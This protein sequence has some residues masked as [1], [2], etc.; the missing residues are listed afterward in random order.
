M[1]R[2]RSWHRARCFTWGWAGWRIE[3]LV[4][5]DGTP[6]STTLTFGVDPTGRSWEKSSSR[7]CRQPGTGMPASVITADCSSTYGQMWRAWRTRCRSPTSGRPV[8]TAGTGGVPAKL[9]D[10]FGGILGI[11]VDMTT[12]NTLTVTNAAIGALNLTFTSTDAFFFSLPL[13]PEVLTFT[14]VPTNVFSTVP[15][16]VV[17]NATD[18]SGVAQAGVSVTISQATGAGSI[19]TSGLTQTTNTSG[20]ATFT[21][22]YTAVAD[23]EAFSLTA[24]TTDCS[25]DPVTVDWSFSAPLFGPPPLN[26][27]PAARA[28]DQENQAPFLF[29]PAAPLAVSYVLDL[30]VAPACESV[31]NDLPVAGSSYQSPTLADGDYCWRVASVDANGSRTPFSADSN[32]TTIPAFGEGGM[33]FLVV[34]IVAVGVWYRRRAADLR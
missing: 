5:E 12:T 3:L 29:W 16:T 20:N 23:G 15:F 32:F 8:A 18:N 19:A 17:V 24:A 6:N 9:Q 7:L 30:G 25:G 22:T 10:Q 4:T 1:G 28:P 34:S 31:A 27:V 26:P 21:I 14:T 33:I 2:G 13:N 11:D